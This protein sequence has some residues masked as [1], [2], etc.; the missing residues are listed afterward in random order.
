MKPNILLYR[1]KKGEK[2]KKFPFM[3]C[4]SNQREGNWKPLQGEKETAFL[5]V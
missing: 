5:K 3:L 1:F 4:S 2:R